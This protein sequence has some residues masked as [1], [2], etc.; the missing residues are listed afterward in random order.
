MWGDIEFEDITFYYEEDKPVLK[1][2][3]LHV[4][5]GETIALIGPTG[6]GK[7]TIVNL[8]C[9]FYEPKA[10]VIRIAGQDY[11]QWTLDSIQSRLGIVLQTPHLFSGAIRENIRYGR[12]GATDAEVEE[13]AKLAHAHEF[14]QELEHGYDQEVGEG[15][16]L[17]SVG[18][19]QL[20]ILARAILAQPNIFIM[21]EATSSVDTLTEGLIQKG[22]A[23]IT[24][25]CTSFIIAHR[26]STIRHADLI[27]VLDNG[28][29]VETGNHEQL[30]ARNGR[31]AEL[32]ASARF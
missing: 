11:T 7:S 18:Q 19:K 14:I 28:R 8:I 5:R 29:L 4:R 17:L 15:G 25:Q 30:L 32:V 16:G 12:L 1:G 31:Y 13:A 27:L 24:A 2:L 20:I 3:N 23:T 21:D 26:L 10:G 6:G 22:I 9:R